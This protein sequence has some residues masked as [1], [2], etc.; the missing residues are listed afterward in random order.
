MRMVL[1]IKTSSRTTSSSEL[2]G[3]LQL[4][5]KMGGGAFHD[6]DERLLEAISAHLA[7]A[8]TNAMLCMLIWG[9]NP[10]RA[11]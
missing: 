6:E 1:F 5:N 7:I 10:R 11:K 8:L 3:V 2:M 9:S 4:S